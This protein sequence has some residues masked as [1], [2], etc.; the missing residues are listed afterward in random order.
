MHGNR[1]GSDWCWTIIVEILFDPSKPYYVKTQE[2]IFFNYNFQNN[3][4]YAISFTSTENIN[5]EWKSWVRHMRIKKNTD[6]TLQL[7]LDENA[8]DVTQ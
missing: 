4:P 3:I 6:G 2:C 7:L 8:I 1:G 5:D